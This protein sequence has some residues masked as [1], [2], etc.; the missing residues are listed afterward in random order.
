MSKSISE[1]ISLTKPLVLIGMM[2]AGKTSIGQA[3]AALLGVPFF[4]SDAEI[5]ASA[6]C[7]V[8][9]I[10]SDYGEREFR[11][12]ERQVI[13]RLL[14]TG[15]CVLSLGG[16]A[17]IDPET[18]EHVKTDALSLWIKV[19]R[20]TLLERVMRHDTRPLLRDE[21][22]KEKFERILSER[23]PIYAL[24]DLVVLCDEGPITHNAQKIMAALQAAQEPQ[25][26]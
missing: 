2:G 7:S 23:E 19:A 1:K 15:P 5:E 25:T 20:E 12:M 10:F 21:N 4:D 24:A 8:S 6:G 14:K 26:L 3:L 9:Q 11:R 13:A 17:F 16:G 18:R 22:P